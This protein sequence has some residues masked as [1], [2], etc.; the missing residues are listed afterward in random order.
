[1]LNLSLAGER[2]EPREH[3]TRSHEIMQIGHA[4]GD[5]NSQPEKNS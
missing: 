1:M 4:S 3:E 5:H 2:E